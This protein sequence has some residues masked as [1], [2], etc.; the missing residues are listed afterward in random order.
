MV[1]LKM[2]SEP[3]PITHSSYQFVLIANPA[4]GER[5]MNEYAQDPERAPATPM[6]PEAER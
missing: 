4:K 6:S 5:L 1:A 3:S 2:V